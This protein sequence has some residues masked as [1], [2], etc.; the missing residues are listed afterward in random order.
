MSEPVA[1]PRPV[2]L[3]TIL[4]ILREGQIE[5]QGLLPYGSNYTFLAKVTRHQQTVFAVYKPTR[6]E[7]PLWDFPENTLAFR[8][9]AAFLVSETLGW[10]MVP[11]TIYRDEGPHGAGSA[12]FFVQA[13][14]DMH[15]FNLP[16]SDKAALRRVVLFDLIVNNADRKGGHVLKDTAGK[17]WLIDHG[18]CFNAQP[19]LRTV[20]WDFGGEPIADE[21][22]QE[23][24]QFRARLADDPD[25]QRALEQLLS[26]SEIVALRRRTDKLLSSKQFPEPGPGRN[27]PWPPL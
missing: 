25:L 15:Y 23:V 24:Q 21:L 18:I 1:P 10:H 12:Q 27:Y 6:G 3:H 13:Q 2:S 22:V 16:D 19:K 11:P 26:P 7:Q 17:L 5:I 20:I 9:V 8:E 4:Q 14:K